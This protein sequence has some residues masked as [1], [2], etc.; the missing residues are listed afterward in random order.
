MANF[1]FLNRDTRFYVQLGADLW[2]VPILADYGFTQAT[3]SSEVTLSEA[4]DSSGDS[5]RGRATFNDALNPA[6][7][8]VNAYIRPYKGVD[9]NNDGDDDDT[10]EGVTHSMVDAVLWAAL[11]GA[12]VYDSEANKGFKRGTSTFATTGTSANAVGT[13]G[14][15]NFNLTFDQ[16]NK[17]QQPEGLTLYFVIGE[18]VTN[19]KRVIRISQ[20][21][22]NEASITFDLEGIATVAWS[23]FGRKMEDITDD[24]VVFGAATTGDTGEVIAYDV[25]GELYTAS[26]DISSSTATSTSNTSKAISTAIA[27]T[28]NLIANRLTQLIVKPNAAFKTRVD[29]DSGTPTLQSEY[30]MALTGGTITLNNNLTFLT[31][32]ELGKVNNPLRNV[33]GARNI[34]GD[35][36]CYLRAADGVGGDTKN[37]SLTFWDHLANLGN[38]TKNVFETTFNIGGTSSTAG[39]D[40][41]VVGRGADGSRTRT[42]TR[43]LPT[44]PGAQFFFPQC[45]F[46]IPAFTIE[47][48]ISFSATFNALPSTITETDEVFI[49]AVGK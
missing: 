17:S 33:T 24:L 22:V 40:L 28:D 8:N 47:D 42:G 5:V 14:S 18:K 31:P 9:F 3:E 12:D 49:T 32:E 48:V 7:W 21:A 37:T 43:D 35:F 46:E 27:N 6:E 20:A 16:S 2:E 34:S 4:E 13:F 45:N 10:G 29:A 25:N 30:R 1:T 36:T 44:A 15:G 19:G 23:G 11:M 38:E 26:S 41:P 39:T